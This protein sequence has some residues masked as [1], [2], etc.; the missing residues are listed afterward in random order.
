MLN[1]IMTV[2]RCQECGIQ[3]SRHCRKCPQC[4]ARNPTA[5]RVSPMGIVVA[6]I[7]LACAVW[8]IKNVQLGYERRE[9]WTTS[10]ARHSS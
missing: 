4:C 8:L 2:Y 3:I 5:P 6:V 9:P 7:L 10:I 1:H